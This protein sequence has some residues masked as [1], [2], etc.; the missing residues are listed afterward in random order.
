MVAESNMED[1]DLMEEDDSDDSTKAES[2]DLMTLE[3]HQKD[4]KPEAVA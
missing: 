4:A 1:D 2:D 3:W